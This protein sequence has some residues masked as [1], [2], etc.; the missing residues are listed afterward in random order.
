MVISCSGAVQLDETSSQGHR[1]E[2]AKESDRAKAEQAQYKPE[3]D[4][5]RSVPTGGYGAFGG[6]G[7][8]TLVVNPT[9]EHLQAAQAHRDHGQQHE[10]A[11]KKL[12]EFEDVACTGIPPAARDACPSLQ[13]LSVEKLPGGVRLQTG[14]QRTDKVLAL[15]RC[16]LAFARATG[17]TGTTL[18]PFSIKGVRAEPSPDHAGVDLLSEDVTAIANLHKLLQSPETGM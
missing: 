15:M 12:E 5:L 3:E 7:L 13:T 14:T 6:A 18:C 8:V 9:D 4:R 10:K 1:A 2:A 11:A 17:Y 16:H